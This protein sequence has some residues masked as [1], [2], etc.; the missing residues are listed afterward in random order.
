MSDLRAVPFAR[1]FDL[2]L[3]SRVSIAPATRHDYTKNF[4]RMESFFGPLPLGQITIEHIDQYRAIRHRTSGPNR[5]NK[6]MNMLQQIMTK[7]GLW[8]PIARWYER[9]PQ[10]RSDI[11]IALEPEEE[12]H[13]F[14]VAA[15][16][17]R[18]LVAY[19]A[20]LISRNT[21]ACPG[22]L[23]MLQLKNIDSKTF[24][25]IRIIAGT[26]N[27]FRIRTVNCNRDAAW[28]L[29]QLYQRAQRKGAILPHHYLLPRTKPFDP[30]QPQR[31][32]W[33]AWHSL[34]RQAATRFPRLRYVRLY[35]CRHTA[36]TRLLENAQV[37]YSA[38]EHFMGHRLDSETKRIYE[39]IRNDT[40]ENAA[41]AICS[42]IVARDVG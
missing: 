15:T 42:G 21:C 10:P 12:E 35:D 32:W 9:L 3:H 36:C 6:E 20:S 27:H 18:W 41:R 14:A 7:A 24:R 1:A 39:H 40:L 34:R 38:I 30:E 31:G 11:G 28:A 13:L 19:C 37:P 25:W 26:K 22:E 4:Q 16:R 33:K 17:K 8:E 5:I 29:E 2:W 23:R